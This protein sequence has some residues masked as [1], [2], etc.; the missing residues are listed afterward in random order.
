MVLHS[1]IY[2]AVV[3]DPVTNDAIDFLFNMRQQISHLGGVLVMAICHRRREHLAVVVDTNRQF[4]P[5]G[6]KLASGAILH[7]LLT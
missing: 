5:N 7:Q 3:V 6:M 1:R 2:R 4:H